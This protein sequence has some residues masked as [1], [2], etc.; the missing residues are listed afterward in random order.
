[1]PLR[2]WIIEFWFFYASVIER[3]KVVF[4]ESLPIFIK[5]AQPT[6]RKE[7]SAGAEIAADK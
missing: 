3:A 2:S 7:W 5:R 4:W 1:M 6:I